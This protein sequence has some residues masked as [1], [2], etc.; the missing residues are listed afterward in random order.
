MPAVHID[1]Q[2]LENIVVVSVTFA[3]Q[4]LLFLPHRHTIYFNRW[5]STC[6][7]GVCP[8]TLRFPIAAA[9]LLSLTSECASAAQW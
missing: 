6:W 4:A 5:H 7:A 3:S 1:L 8:C 9:D 2:A